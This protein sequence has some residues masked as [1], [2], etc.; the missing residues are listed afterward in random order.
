MTVE[1]LASAVDSPAMRKGGIA[2][3]RPVGWVWGT[4]EGLP[5]WVQATVTGV[6]FAEARDFM[7]RW[8]R[9]VSV[10]VVESD[11][12]VDRHRLRISASPI[13]TSDGKGAITREQ[14]E[15]FLAEWRAEVVSFG[16]NEVVCDV[17]VGEMAASRGFFNADVSGVT[18][19]DAYD[20]PSGTHTI[21][22]QYSGFSA[23]VVS[24]KIIMLGGEVLS[25]DGSE[26]IYTV[27]RPTLRTRFIE[28]LERTFSGDVDRNRWYIA[29][30]AV[31][32][33]VA[34][35]GHMQVTL[36]QLQ[37]N[38]RDALNG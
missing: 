36:A 8:R 12:S 37:S 26:V 15:A 14:V 2:A 4:R 3:V 18:F 31:D 13:R 27:D 16:T 9:Q 35:G 17:L 7:A 34:N 5:N 24:N 28:D 33:V 29:P 19:S 25:N 23:N 10:E 11:L 38:L 6:S 21:T 30:A 20:Q 32:Q 22:A 1:L